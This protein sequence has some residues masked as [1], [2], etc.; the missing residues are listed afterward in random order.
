MGSE[1]E[2]YGELSDM[3]EVSAVPSQK[4][5]EDENQMLKEV[6]DEFIAEKKD[7]FHKLNKQ[8]GDAKPE[9]TAI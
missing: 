3:D 7:W 1:F 2:E 5:V 4:M 9:E 8:Y 6:A